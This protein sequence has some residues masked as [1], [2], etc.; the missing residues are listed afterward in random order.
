VSINYR[1][2]PKHQFPAQIDD[3]RTAVAWL[4][5][6]AKQL[7]IDAARVGGFGYS[8]GAHL[9]SLLATQ[10]PQADKQIEVE[11]TKPAL[12]CVVAGGAPCDFRQLPPD[13]KFLAYWLGGTRAEKPL[14][15]ELAS[16]RRFVTASAAPAFYFHGERD[17]LVPRESPEQM[18]ASLQ[19]AGVKASL[20]VVPQAGHAAALFSQE[21]IARAIAF[22]DAEL[23]HE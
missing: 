14:Q 12:R 2:A 22:L 11:A 16:P 1:L 23:K 19:Q 8:A 21:A 10:A 7:K 13:A 17:F 5:S 15:Y 6:E 20:Y 4:Q 3:C 9:V 18:V